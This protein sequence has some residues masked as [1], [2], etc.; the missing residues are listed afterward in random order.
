MLMLKDKP[1]SNAILQAKNR[2]KRQSKSSDKS[3]KSA[4]NDF[5]LSTADFHFSSIFKR[6]YY[7]LHTFLE[8]YRCLDKRL[9]I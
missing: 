1:I 5:S 7:V 8:R 2:P 3:L 9:S 6:Q 4:Q